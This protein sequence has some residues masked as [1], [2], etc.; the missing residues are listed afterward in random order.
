MDNEMRGSEVEAE[1]EVSYCRKERML[2]VS[3]IWDS[4]GLFPSGALFSE[5]LVVNSGHT[6]NDLYKLRLVADLTVLR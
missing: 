1:V 3:V 6:L 4:H 2:I 5:D